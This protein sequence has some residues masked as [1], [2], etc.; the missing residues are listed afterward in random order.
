MVA[1]AHQVDHLALGPGQRHVEQPQVLPGLL[2]QVPGTALLPALAGL[3]ADVEHPVT[4]LVVQ[5]RHLRVAH[6]AVPAEGQV[7]DRELQALA[8]GGW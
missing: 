2:G 7:D 5:Q 8:R 6:V 4:G 3:A 1:G